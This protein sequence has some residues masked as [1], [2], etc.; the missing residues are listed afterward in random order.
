MSQLSAP[1]GARR[2]LSIKAKFAGLVVGATFVSCLSVGLLSYQIG[3]SGLIEASELRLES[4]A[5]NQA[6]GLAAYQQR[7]SQSLAELAQNTAIGQA[8]E[9]MT[10][11]IPSEVDSIRS[12][13]QKSELS[14][15]ERAAF[16]GAGLK[17]L[18][19]IHHSAIHGT[20][21]SAWKNAGVSDIYIT[22]LNGQIVYSVT[23]GSELLASAADIPQINDL[24]TRLTAGTG[25][26]VQTLGF[27]PYAPDGDKPSAFIGRQLAVSSWGQTVTKGIV[28]MRISAERLTQAVTP[29]EYGKS[30]DEA[31]LLDAN[32]AFRSGSFVDGEAHAVPSLLAEAATSQQAGSAF[33]TV[34]DQP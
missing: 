14:A 23:K 16:D 11:I 15:E 18:Y 21:A 17:L 34:A 25:S 1:A 33:A 27:S 26:D 10:N 20:I 32:G 29:D 31:L 4:I 28:I 12:E 9:T 6:K 24:V 3:K 13:Y 7:I 30:I 22:D 8:V 2:S 5:G 19:A